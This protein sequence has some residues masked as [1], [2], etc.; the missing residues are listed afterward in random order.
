[1][2]I[3][4]SEAV[5][6]LDFGKCLQALEDRSGFFRLARLSRIRVPENSLG[7][8]PKFVLLLIFL[9]VTFVT[10]YV[11]VGSIAGAVALPIVTLWGSW[12][13]GKMDDGTWNKPLFVFA[14][15]AGAMAVWKHREN[16]ARLRAG[17]ESKIGTK[18]KKEVPS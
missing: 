16:I 8:T 12:F 1:V 13:H 6:V 17:T 14:L 9:I 18:A 3:A 15:I 10:K 5:D 4:L 7:E 2:V 11:S